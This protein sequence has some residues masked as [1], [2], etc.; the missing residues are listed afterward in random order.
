MLLRIRQ[1]AKF[2]RQQLH[3]LLFLV[4]DIVQR[5]YHADLADVAQIHLV[6]QDA[7]DW[8]VGERFSAEL[9]LDVL[10]LHGVRLV[11]HPFERVSH[12]FGGVVGA[13]KNVADLVLLRKVVHGGKKCV[14]LRTINM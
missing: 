4:G 6:P 5:S 1:P 11:V 7:G 14:I 13:G 12:A 8:I 2:F 10:E 9:A 3:G